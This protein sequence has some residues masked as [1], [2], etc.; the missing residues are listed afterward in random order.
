MKVLAGGCRVYGQEDGPVSTNGNWTARTVISKGTGAEHITQ[1]VSTYTAGLSPAVVN[2]NAEEALYI[3]A[4]SGICHIDGFEYPISQGAAIFI[5]P[6]AV[7]SI[8]NTGVDSIRIVSACCPEDPQRHIVE[9]PP[10]ADAGSRSNLMVHENDREAIRAGKDRQFRYL[11]NAELDCKQITQ[12]A[13]WIPPSKA[14]IHYHTY[15]EG[16]YILEGHG[17]VH[18]DDDSCEFG[19]GSSVYFPIGV[20]HCVENPGA[21]VI[22]LLGAFYPS[23]SPAVAY[24]DD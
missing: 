5:P 2:P 10:A 16:I 1:T 15:E 18:A 3:A 7:Y 8:E 23:G 9:N 20:R 11:V 6:G 12:F 14:P 21:S 13:G 4:G 24:E 17:V 22:K 19:P